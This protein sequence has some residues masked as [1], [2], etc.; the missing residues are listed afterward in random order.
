M[1]KR[2]AVLAALAGL[3]AAGCAASQAASQQQTASQ[4]P[5]GFHYWWSPGSHKAADQGKEFLPV[6]LAYLQGQAPPP[7][8]ACHPQTLADLMLPCDKP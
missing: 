5:A 4:P 3:V 6:Y 7:D 2:I 1:K 8:N